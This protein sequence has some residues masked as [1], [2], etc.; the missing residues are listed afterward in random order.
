MKRFNIH[1]VPLQLNGAISLLDRPIDHWLGMFHVE[2]EDATPAITGTLQPYEQREVLRTLSA[3]AV[4]LATPGLEMGGLMELYQEDERFWLVD[5]RW[6]MAEL[7][8]LKGSWRSWILPQ[9][10]LD[11]V[12]CAELAVLWPMAQMMRARGLHF[13]PASSL[14]SNDCG[15]LILAPMGI[16]EELAA[17]VQ[18]G[19]RVIGQRWTCLRIEGDAIEMLHMAG[20]V[21][22]HVPRLTN[23]ADQNWVNL[24][25][26]NG[27]SMV[28]SAECNMVL[29]VEAARRPVAHA[30]SV[31]KQLALNHLRRSWPM[32]ELHGGR[33]QMPMKLASQCRCISVQL[34][35]RPQDLLVLL[36]SLGNGEQATSVGE[37]P[38]GKRDRRFVHATVK[39]A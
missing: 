31:P 9:P 27:G 17:L 34:S 29:M 5:D 22:S 37:A 11:P 23:R 38:H 19:F 1:G 32:V 6:G 21:P 30:K 2:H 12:R 35:R 7:N 33:R 16:E 36:S 4:R 14:A 24:E 15:V 13:L 28:A 39:V 8:L 10:T 3:R 26:L 25:G 20:Q 18:G